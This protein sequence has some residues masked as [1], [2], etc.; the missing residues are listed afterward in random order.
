MTRLA[1]ILG[2]PCIFPVVAYLLTRRTMESPSRNGLEMLVMMLL[3]GVVAMVY[4]CVALWRMR[5]QGRAGS[6]FL[7]AGIA[8]SPAVYFVLWNA[9]L[10]ASHP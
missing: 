7:G 4:G 2:L 5:S 1:A 8:L 10:R 9:F 6:W 3:G